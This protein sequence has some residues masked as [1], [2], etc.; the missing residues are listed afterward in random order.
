MG[1]ELRRTRQVQNEEVAGL[2]EGNPRRSTP[3]PTAEKLLSAFQGI[4]L[5]RH[6][7][8]THLEHEITPLSPLQVRILELMGIPQTIY[9]G[10]E[11]GPSG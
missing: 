9:A 4:T 1:F 5:Y 11:P 7:G 6:P 8:N 2:Y 3:R 10:P